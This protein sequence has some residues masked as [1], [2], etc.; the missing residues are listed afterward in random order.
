MLFNDRKAFLLSKILNVGLKDR[1][2]LVRER[3]DDSSN[4]DYDRSY[5][6][7]R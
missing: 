4:G 7:N 1:S 2:I 6:F 5:L 3:N